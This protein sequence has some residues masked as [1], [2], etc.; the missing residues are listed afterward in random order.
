MKI[1]RKLYN[2]GLHSYGIPNLVET[3]H[4]MHVGEAVAVKS[5]LPV[6]QET[7]R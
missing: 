3:G 7:P 4:V 1:E 6:P 2:E 5:A